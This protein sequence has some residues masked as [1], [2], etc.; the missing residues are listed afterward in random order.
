MTTHIQL[1]NISKHFKQQVLFD[2]ISINFSGNK[3]IG[4]VGENGSGKSVLFK[5]IAGFERPNQGEIIVD[6]TN[7]TKT[8]TFPKN[9]GVLIEEPAFIDHLSGYE[10][11]KLLASIKNKITDDNLLSAL[12]QVGLFESKDKKAKNYS[13]GMKKKLGIAQAIMENQHILL[14]DEPMNALDEDSVLKTRQLFKDLVK[15]NKTIFIA[16]HNKEDIR[17]LCDEVYQIKNH[18]LIKKN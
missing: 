15:Q 14:L 6:S 1:K 12:K 2:N 17:E 8:K 4:I 7:L 13:L 16:S 11:L 9:M 10:N 5:L 3:I 18:R